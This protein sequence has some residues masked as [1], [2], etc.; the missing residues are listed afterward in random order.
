MILTISHCEV[1]LGA[2]APRLNALSG[3]LQLHSGSL[4][5]CCLFTRHSLACSCLSC[6]LCNCSIGA[7]GTYTSLDC[8]ICTDSCVVPSRISR[9]EPT[10]SVSSCHQCLVPCFMHL[11]SAASRQPNGTALRCCMQVKCGN[12]HS[13]LGRSHSHAARLHACIYSCL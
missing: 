8:L 12:S 11:L 2:V 1:R 13:W 4:Q 10:W 9:F 7:L 6:I 3:S 5:Q